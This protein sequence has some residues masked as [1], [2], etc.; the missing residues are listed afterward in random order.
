MNKGE[1]LCLRP[2]LVDHKKYKFALNTHK[3]ILPITLRP[4]YC[5]LLF[6]AIYSILNNNVL[7]SRLY[8]TLSHWAGRARSIASSYAIGRMRTAWAGVQ[9]MRLCDTV[10]IHVPASLKLDQSRARKFSDMAKSRMRTRD[11][12]LIKCMRIRNMVD[13]HMCAR[14]SLP[15]L[16]KIARAKLAKWPICVRA[17]TRE[18]SLIIRRAMARW[19]KCTIQPWLHLL[20]TFGKNNNKEKGIKL[21]Q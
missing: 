21:D 9:C 8:Y 1:Q 2:R 18:I 3:T 12:A 10:N 4:P 14:A 7:H 16:A 6:H 20:F 13:S 5:G 15:L 19:P 11:F 17:R